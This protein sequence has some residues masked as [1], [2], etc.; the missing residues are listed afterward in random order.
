MSRK[1]D[2]SRARHLRA[3]HRSHRR[4]SRARRASMGQAMECGQHGWPHHA[5]A[6]P[7]RQPYQRHER[8]PAVVGSRRARLHVADLDDVQ[9]VARTRRPRPQGRDGTAWWSTP[10]G[11]Q[12]PRR[13]SM[14]TRSNAISRSCSA[15]TVFCVDQIDGLPEHYYGRPATVLAPSQRNAH[16]DAFFANTGAD[17]PAWRRQGVLRALAPTTSRCRRSRVFATPRVY[18]AV[19]AH[20]CVHWTAPAHRVNRDLSRYAKDRSERAREELVAELGA[21]SFARTSASCP[22][23]SR[24]PIMRAT[25]RPGWRCCPTTSALSS[26]AAAHAQRAVDLPA[27]ASAEA[28]RNRARRHDAQ[29]SVSIH[30]G[31]CWPSPYHGDQRR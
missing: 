16:A 7:Q 20:E 2:K 12:R 26:R 11:S 30:A 13:T 21:A 10:A 15:Y 18:V 8:H 23:S 28:G 14:A 5:A 25:S 4:R 9:A 1:E 17:H 3:H 22:N 31:A 19:R 24:A 29:T 27:R 6:A